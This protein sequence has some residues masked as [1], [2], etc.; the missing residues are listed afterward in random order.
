[1]IPYRFNGIIPPNDNYAIIEA[2]NDWITGG[3]NDFVVNWHPNDKHL[4][5]ISF[6]FGYVENKLDSSKYLFST[7]YIKGYL[8]KGEEYIYPKYGDYLLRDILKGKEEK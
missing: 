2:G 6:E 1:M 3:A 7:N 4:L 8:D 5:K